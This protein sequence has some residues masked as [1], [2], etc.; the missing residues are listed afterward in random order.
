MGSSV[1]CGGGEVSWGGLLFCPAPD[2][3]AAAIGSTT[4]GVPFGG[5]T[6]VF[7]GKEGSASEI[8]LGAGAAGT[9]CGV[10]SANSAKSWVMY[11]RRPTRT[12]PMP[13]WVRSA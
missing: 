9:S 4:E 3:G 8:A 6:G 1:V 13:I 11:T 2:E 12:T 7:P 5:D 10:V